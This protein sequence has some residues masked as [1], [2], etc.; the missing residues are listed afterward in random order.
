MGIVNLYFDLKL[1]ASY[2]DELE[3]RVV[4][5]IDPNEKVGPG[6]YGPAGFVGNNQPLSYTIYCENLATASAAA[7][8]VLITD[9]LD[10]SL[11]S[12]TLRLTEIAFGSTVIVVP[13][14]PSYYQQRFAL[15]PD[16]G[17]ILA[18]VT[19]G[20]DIQTGKV[21]L[22]AKAID[23]NTGEKPESPALGV[24]L[25]NNASHIGEGRF[26][27]TISPKSGMPTG[28]RLANSAA[29]VF[30]DNEPIITNTVQNTLD[31]FAPSSAVAQL[32]AV[33]D[34]PAFLV[35][36]SGGDDSTGSGMKSFDVLVADNNGEW[37]L[38]QAE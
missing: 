12:R 7:Q 2:G 29:I 30:D 27:Y 20:V 10:P 34:D 5:P 18:D 15:G 26:S 22:V 33:S 38:W 23:P 3:V 1:L 35:S 14:N 31:A 28:T 9:S 24:L 8:E 36:W 37:T 17:N 6:G 19:A 16:Y 13:F 21:T 25:P 11:D 32:P 4:R